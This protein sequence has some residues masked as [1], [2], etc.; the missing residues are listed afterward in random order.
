MIAGKIP[1]HLGED[2]NAALYGDLG[3]EEVVGEEALLEP[4]ELQK[5]PEHRRGLKVDESPHDLGR[6]AAA[7]HGCGEVGGQA[8]ELPPELRQNKQG[9]PPVD[10]GVVVAVALALAIFISPSASPARGREVVLAA[11]SGDA[12][13]AVGRGGREGREVGPVEAERGEVEREGAQEGEGSGVERR[14]AGEGL[15]AEVDEGG[16]GG[17][18]EGG[19]ARR[20]HGT[21]AWMCGGVEGAGGGFLGG[22]AGAGCGFLGGSGPSTGRGGGCVVWCPVRREEEEPR[23]SLA[24]ALEHGSTGVGSQRPTRWARAFSRTASPSGVGGTWTS[25]RLVRPRRPKLHAA[26]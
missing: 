14:E 21:G 23:Q 15:E 8:L 11:A 17:E 18:G 19:G 7:L 10:R 20:G 3:E 13:S 1:A 26:G 24:R 9:L 16:G 4:T 22:S 6:D 25:S 2:A 5:P 12:A